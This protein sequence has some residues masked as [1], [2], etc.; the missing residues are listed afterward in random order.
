MHVLDEKRRMLD[1]KLEKCILIGYSHEQKEYKCYNPR[2]KQ[3]RVNRD[4][5]FN[6]SKV[7]VFSSISDPEDSIPIIEDKNNEAELIPE[8]EGIDTLK[9]SLISFWLSGLNDELDRDGQPIDM[10]ASEEDSIVQSP[11]WK[12]RK[13]LTGKEKGNNKMPEHG[14]LKG[15][16]DRSKSDEAMSEEELRSRGPNRPRGP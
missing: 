16:S 13:R 10:S 1:A 9:E 2:T 6:E 15:T 3:V 11:W 4:V 12:P 5:V 7:L 14:N 8:E